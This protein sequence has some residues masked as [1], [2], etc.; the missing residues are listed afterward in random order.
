MSEKTYTITL[1]LTA[2]ELA[3]LIALAVEEDK[4]LKQ[5]RYY[6]AWADN[7]EG[8]LKKIKGLLYHPAFDDGHDDL[9]YAGREDE[10]PITQY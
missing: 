2:N 4:R 8:F 7:W 1:H 3:M 9:D 5:N 6:S 10:V